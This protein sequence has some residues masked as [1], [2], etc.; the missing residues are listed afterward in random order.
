MTRCSIIAKLQFTHYNTNNQTQTKDIKEVYNLCAL[1]NPKQNDIN[2]IPLSKIKGI[3]T[4]R[5]TK[6]T[7]FFSQKTA[8]KGIG[9]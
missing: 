8:T 5:G 1:S 6:S 4:R 9:F 2:C 7:S 3:K